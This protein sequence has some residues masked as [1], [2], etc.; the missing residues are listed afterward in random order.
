MYWPP[1]HPPQAEAAKEA[2]MKG[3]HSFGLQRLLTI[4]NHLHSSSSAGE[5]TNEFAL[6]LAGMGG[7]LGLEMDLLA[8]LDQA[9]AIRS[10]LDQD[11]QRTPS[12]HS[13]ALSSISM[14]AS[15]GLF[16]KVRRL[17]VGWECG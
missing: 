5:H 12:E 2:R 1:T 13:D 17:R 10:G 9:H 7:P 8:D 16:S 14:L 6:A 4:Y 11:K 3:P 15:V